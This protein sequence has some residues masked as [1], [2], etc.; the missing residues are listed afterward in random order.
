[1]GW[2]NAIP[3]GDIVASFDVQGVNHSFSGIG[4]HDKNWGSAPFTD[5][6]K[7]WDW[8]H[9][10]IGEYSL[11]WFD[12]IGAD[13][14]EYVSGYVAKDGIIIEASCQKHAVMVRPTNGQY[15]PTTKTAWPD[16]F[17]MT[18]DIACGAKLD[19]MIQSTAVIFESPLYVRWKGI[20]TGGIQGQQNLTS[21]SAL[22]E[23]FNVLKLS[24]LNSTAD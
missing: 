17:T 22:W 18:F 16:G 12:V 14:K 20:L 2:A 19:V 10:R 8:G 3:D 24:T 21:G 11:V 5:N 15:P 6:I 23:E 9:G 1:M 4:Y 7:S 13:D